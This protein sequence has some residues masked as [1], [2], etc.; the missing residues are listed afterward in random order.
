M[1]ALANASRCSSSSSAAGA[2]GEQVVEAEVAGEGPVLGGKRAHVLE[3]RLEH[4]IDA[5]LRRGRLLFGRLDAAPSTTGNAGA[6]SAIQARIASM[7]SAV[8]RG[9]PG[10]A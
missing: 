5:G 7:S 6:P 1:I 2:G 9:C 8:S 10:A 4:E 3:D